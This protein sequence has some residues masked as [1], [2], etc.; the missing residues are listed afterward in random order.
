M[1]NLWG[2]WISRDFRT[3]FCSGEPR[4]TIFYTGLLIREPSKNTTQTPG[5]PSK[6]EDPVKTNRIIF[7][8][9]I[10][11]TPWKTTGFWP[12]P[13]IFIRGF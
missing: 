2:N 9:G 4:K 1:G 5:K 13:R 10:L 8:T 7:F 11:E 12:E 3:G 6:N